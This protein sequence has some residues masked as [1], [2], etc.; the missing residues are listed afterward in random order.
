M[1]IFTSAEVFRTTGISIIIAGNSR[2]YE[3][4][5]CPMVWKCWKQEGA[6]AAEGE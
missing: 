2:V 4:R 6:A 5:K 3:Y 1:F